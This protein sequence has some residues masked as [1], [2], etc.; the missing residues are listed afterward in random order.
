M[1]KGKLVFESYTSDKQFLLKN[2]A[3]GITYLYGWGDVFNILASGGEIQGLHMDEGGI[4][5]VVTET[6]QQRL[7]RGVQV[8]QAQMA[9]GMNAK[10]RC[11]FYCR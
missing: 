1:R 8:T 6:V 2:T 5:H 11:K 10:L 7:A 3:D 4:Y 9:R